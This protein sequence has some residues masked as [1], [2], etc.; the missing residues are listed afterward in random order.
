MRGKKPQNHKKNPQKT[1]TLPEDHP[2][3]PPCHR[4]PQARSRRS[5]AGKVSKG[6]RKKTDMSPGWWKRMLTMCCEC[7]SPKHAQT[8]NT[9]REALSG[10]TC[11]IH[12]WEGWHRSN[13]PR[14]LLHYADT[15]AP[16]PEVEHGWSTAATSAYRL[17]NPQCLVPA[18]Q[19]KVFLSRS[20]QWEL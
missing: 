2:A 12:G 19:W 20:N 10:A 11:K 3:P 18:R 5:V 14:A 15:G 7:P 17:S 1:R 16:D 8:C 6:H 4:H 9:P 13:A